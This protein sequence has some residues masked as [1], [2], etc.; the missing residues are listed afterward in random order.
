MSDPSLKLDEYGTIEVLPQHR[1]DESRLQ[2]YLHEYLPQG[3]SSLKVRQFQGGQ[4]NPTFL[5][6]IDGT[7]F[8]LRKKPP[9][10]LLRGAHQV[11]RE[12]RVMKSLDGSAVPVPQMLH[13][14][15]DEDVIGTIFFVMQY[16]DGRVEQEPTLSVFEQSQRTPMF[17]QM[18]S[19]LARLHNVDWQAVGLEGFGRAENYIGRQISTWSKQYEASKTD[20]MPA[21]DKLM[22]WLSNREPPESPATIAHGD[23]RVGN[24][25][26]GAEHTNIIAVL[27]WELSTI[28]HPLADLGYFC[29]PWYLPADLSGVRGLKGRDLESE[30]LPSVDLIVDVYRRERGLTEEIDL[31]YF[32]AFSLFRLAA[33]V[34]GV[35]ARGLQG[36]ASSAD[37]ILVGKRAALL[38]QTGWSIV[39]HR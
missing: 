31:D 15:E 27:D 12:F 22:A 4:S 10:K 8:V 39:E 30:G 25:M 17:E 24:L 23:F 13:L 18:A 11:D 32:V 38:A 14:C 36:N 9:G 20:E 5:I 6:F 35:Y 26:F 16:L 21:M 28:G 33:I 2:Q 29:L 37:A 34:Q 1:F 7:P 3:C 19:T